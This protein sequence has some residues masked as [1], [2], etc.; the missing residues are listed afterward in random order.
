MKKTASKVGAYCTEQQL[1]R[2]PA[3]M[4]EIAEQAASVDIFGS[5]RFLVVYF[6]NTATVGQMME[7]LYWPKAYEAPDVSHDGEGITVKCRIKPEYV[8][9]LIEDTLKA[10][11]AFVVNSSTFVS[12]A[13]R[14]WAAQIP[15]RV[16]S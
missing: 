3:F 16:R 8:R 11:G 14:K 5:R 12:S 2:D 7:A 4:F 1:V 15:S 13:T 6:P 10:G 9:H